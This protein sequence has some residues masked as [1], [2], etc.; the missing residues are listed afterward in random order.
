MTVNKNGRKSMKPLT[1]SLIWFWVGI[2]CL[3]VAIGY[4]VG[5]SQ[6]PVIATLLPLLFGLIGGSSGFLVARIKDNDSQ[7]IKN[8]KYSCIAIVVFSI[9]VMVSSFI[10]LKHRTSGGQFTSQDELS[11]DGV[12]P[13]MGIDLIAIRKQ[14][15]V[16][17]ASKKERTQILQHMLQGKVIKASTKGEIEQFLQ[18]LSTKLKATV[19][20]IEVALKKGV[21]QLDEDDRRNLEALLAI[22]KAVDPMFKHWI[23][24][25]S[26]DEKLPAMAIK[27]VLSVISNN[28]DELIGTG[29]GVNLTTISKLSHNPELLR[30]LLEL[31]STYWTNVPRWNDTSKSGLLSYNSFHLDKLTELLLSQKGVDKQE[32]NAGFAFNAKQPRS[33][34]D[35]F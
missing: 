28:L 26:N 17:G 1:A 8:V 4:F 6:S 29:D 5:L 9:A 27:K 30:N 22:L 10:A 19:P 25:L 21:V 32:E 23:T 2:G 35:I 33:L 34:L 11:L 7:S 18:N 13:E 24:S 15:Q 16:L 31:Q 3:G 14:L 12:T 20:I